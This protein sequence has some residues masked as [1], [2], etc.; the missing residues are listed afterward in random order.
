[1]TANSITETAYA[2]INLALDITGR[3]PNGYHTVRMVMETIS[4][5]DDLTI[6]LS[7]VPGI[8]LTCR[9]EDNNLSVSE[10]DCGEDNLIVRSA[11][12]LLD[13]AEK[14]G[15]LGNDA[16]EN[17]HL[18]KNTDK[19]SKHSAEEIGLDIELI[20]RIPMAAGMAGGSSDAAATLRGINKLLNL[21]YTDEELC[22]TGVTIGADVPYC[23]LGGSMLAEGIGEKLT[24]IPAPPDTHILIAKP[25]IDVSTAY[26]YKMI[27]SSP[28][29]DHP[30]VD[31]MISAIKDRDLPGM[32]AE[33]GNVLRDVT[34]Q[35]HAI[36]PE[37]EQAMCTQGA[38]GAL[39]SGSGP[40]V[41]GLFD[42]KE[43]CMRALDHIRK[44]Y[45]D[46][47]VSDAVFVSR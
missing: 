7:D 43:T 14:T 21:G 2:K 24:P 41:F 40:T 35:E 33:L 18:T 23:I 42:N 27:D 22:I 16:G 12:A 8:R 28:E 31:G 1:M 45:P 20:K 37:L 9:M 32:A 25:D 11:R 5:H 15:R 36:V 4:I 38:K 39:M 47:Y 44:L 30:D 46:I 6:T 10:L 3:L 13:N 26:V 34:A 19:S 29:I 17:K